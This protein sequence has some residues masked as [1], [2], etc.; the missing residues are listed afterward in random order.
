MVLPLQRRRTVSTSRTTTM[1]LQL[2]TRANCPF[3]AFG[4]LARANGSRDERGGANG[5]VAGGS[6]SAQTICP[7]EPN[8]RF[9]PVRST[10]NG[11]RHQYHD[12]IAAKVT[13]TSSVAKRN[14]GRKALPGRDDASVVGLG[15]DRT[16]PELPPDRSKFAFIVPRR[17]A[18]SNIFPDFRRSLVA[19]RP[20]GELPACKCRPRCRRLNF[21]QNCGNLRRP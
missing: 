21:R 10:V 9:S 7:S 18:A 6:L 14:R 4:V 3:D 19:K 13:R 1:P 17:P 12:P 2:A 5:S 11:R 8:F 15:I 16:M 20:F